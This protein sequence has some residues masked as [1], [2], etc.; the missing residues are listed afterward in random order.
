[1]LRAIGVAEGLGEPPPD[2]I[3]VR[4]DKAWDLY[5]PE[6]PGDLPAGVEP[7]ALPL[8]T[9]FWEAMGH[10]AGR[11]SVDGPEQVW[12]WCPLMTPAGRNLVIR[13]ASFW[14]TEIQAVGAGGALVGPNLWQPP[15]AHV[16]V[17]QV[18][19][20]ADPPAWHPRGSGERQH[21]L[22]PWL[23]VG[24]AFFRVEVLG[25]GGASARLHSHSAVDEYYLVLEGRGTLRMEDQAVPVGPGNLVA[26]PTGPDVTSQILADQG[27]EVRLLDMEIWP[28]AD[29]GSKDLVT[30]SDH[31]EILLRGGGWSALFPVGA[32]LSPADLGPH[33]QSGY[34]RHADGTWSPAEVPGATARPAVP[35]R[36]SAD[37]RSAA[38]RS[39]PPGSGLVETRFG[40][41]AV[42]RHQAGAGLPI[43][44]LHGLGSA[45][46]VFDRQRPWL[47]DREL[48][49]PDLLG[50]GGSDRPTD[51]DYSPAGQAAAVVDMLN[52]LDVVRCD[53]VGHSMG[54]TVALALQALFP[55]RVARLV[56]AEPNLVS[57]GGLISRRALDLSEQEYVRLGLHTVFAEMRPGPAARPMEVH[58]WDTLADADPRAMHRASLQLVHLDLDGEALVRGAV[59]FLAGAESHDGSLA[60][61]RAA[62]VPV[63]IID[64]AGH[65]M[66]SD[67]PDGTGR[68]LKDWLGASGP[69]E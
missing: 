55:S 66:F 6:H 68:A 14:S 38:R 35:V 69:G 23:G 15:L 27:E 7:G 17:D 40:A 53:L 22:M 45:G 48:L 4:W 3:V 21:F 39:R 13:L 43:V 51:G 28:S 58:Y 30:Y 59:G 18:M 56:V 46:R 2:R 26:K 31:Q 1:M 29:R 36:A 47:T 16:L 34:Q 67:N 64:G 32:L 8:A 62:G 65:D 10:V 25:S 11:L 20:P 12:C 52:A 24:R 42:R 41:M 44:F 57:G 63:A 33:Y 9:W 60:V 49:A 54:G 50:F 61:A 37:D 19:G 5:A